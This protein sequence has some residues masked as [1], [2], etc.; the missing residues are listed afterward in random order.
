[1]PVILI[2]HSLGGVLGRAILAGFPEEVRHVVA[3]GSP[4][5][6][7][8]GALNPRVR[9]ALMAVQAFWQRIVSAPAGCG[10]ERCE[11]GA[12][13]AAMASLPSGAFTAIYSRADEVVNWRKCIDENGAHHEVSGRHASLIVNPQVYR[14][15]AAVLAEACAER[16]ASGRLW[17]LPQ[18]FK[19]E[20]NGHA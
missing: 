20:N 19:R 5:G 10:T 16:A 12:M 15:L 9:P 6:D 4:V 3:L 11:C 8:E 7:P 1:M 13:G 14:T 17:W 2:G 18:D